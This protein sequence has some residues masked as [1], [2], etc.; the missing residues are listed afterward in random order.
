MKS[1]RQFA[2]IPVI[3]LLA[4]I[5]TSCAP[6]IKQFFP[7]RY[8]L[9]DTIYEN[10]TLQFLITYQRGW[11]LFTES[12]EMDQATKRFAA[13]LHK[14]HQELL[15]AGATADGLYGSRCIA[16]NLN[17]PLKEFTANIRRANSE[18]VQNDQ[19]TVDFIAGSVPAEKWIFDQ[20]GFRFVEYFFKINTCNIRIAFWTKPELF[21]NYTGVF[22]E[23]IS[24]LTVTGPLL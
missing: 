24:T 13:S 7:G 23:I 19:G 4:L 5:F 10:K 3:L 8:Y 14:N 11:Y 17:L 22:E 12:Y 20:M 6:Q 2:I 18:S 16:A 1:V 21:D 9:E 15:F